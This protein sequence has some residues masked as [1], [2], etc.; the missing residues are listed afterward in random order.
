MTRCLYTNGLASLKAGALRS[1]PRA[2]ETSATGVQNQQQQQQQQQQFHGQVI[3]DSAW[4]TGIF[5]EE[6]N[7]QTH[8]H[9][10]EKKRKKK[11]IK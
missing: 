3:S 7:K 10:K 1:Q 5:K 8:T 2:T 6:R 11:L 4:N 9:K